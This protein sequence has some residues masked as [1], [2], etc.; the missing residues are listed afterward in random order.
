MK[1]IPDGPEHYAHLLSESLRRELLAVREGKGWALSKVAI[2]FRLCDQAV[3]DHEL[4]K[5]IPTFEHLCLHC[6]QLNR[7]LERLLPVAVRR[8]WPEY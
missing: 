8:W 2:P 3:R 1:V 7:R 5:Y 4:G 6:W